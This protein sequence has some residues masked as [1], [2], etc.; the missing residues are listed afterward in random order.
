MLAR[1]STAATLRSVMNLSLPTE[2][3][4]SGSVRLREA[5]LADL[6]EQR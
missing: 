1:A 5:T 2:L 3:T 6:P 4:R